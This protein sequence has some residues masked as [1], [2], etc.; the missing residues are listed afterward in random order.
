VH[1]GQSGVT[2]RPLARATR[3]P[4]IAL[5]TVGACGFGSPDSLVNFSRG[6]IAFSRERRVRRRANL[7]TGHYPVHHR[8][9][10]VW[11]NS[12]NFLQLNFF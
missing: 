6:A 11:L 4:L 8:L 10:M 1:T 9:V 12:A 3:R 7:G 2:N 5:S